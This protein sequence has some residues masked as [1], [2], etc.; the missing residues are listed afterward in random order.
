MQFP[1]RFRWLD[2][3]LLVAV[4]LFSS[5]ALAKL[6]LAPKEESDSIAVV[7][8]P[9]TSAAE[10]FVRASEAGGRFV[11]FGAFDFIAIVELRPSEAEQ[12]KSAWLILD[13][14]ALAAC[15]KPLRRAS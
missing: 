4:A 8:S 1:V 10:T 11:R 7:F 15:L 6:H 3:L 2:V 13:P 9:W 12:I 5:G 14:V